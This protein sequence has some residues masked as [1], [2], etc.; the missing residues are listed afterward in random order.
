VGGIPYPAPLSTGQWAHD[1]LYELGDPQSPT[2]VGYWE[3]WQSRESPSGYGY[4][5]VGTEQTA[6]GSIVAPGNSATVQAFRSW[7]Q[8]L[9]ATKQTI[10]QNPANAQLEAALRSGNA[11]LAQLAAA[12]S[13][14]GASWATG[15]ESQITALGTST[16]FSY[17]GPMGLQK[18]S[19]GV[20]SVAG[21][22][23]P[24]AGGPG[25][26]DQIFHPLNPFGSN[27]LGLGT[28]G[29][30]VTGIPG[31]V[32]KSAFGPVF[33]WIEKG[34]ADVT[35]VGFGLLLVVIGLSVTFKGGA[36]MNVTQAAPASTSGGV[37]ETA[38]DA[39]EVAAA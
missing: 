9:L 22:K 1:I 25:L 19:P 10:T 30:T 35:F 6:P 36:S 33:S 2:N 31:D 32:A 4:N 8:G 13:V 20:A 17:G 16:P 24:S 3:A 5:P 37:K 26:L 14:P 15:G 18:G 11:T 38:S 27:F 34:A 29:H 39:A 7:A 12:Q 28:V 23:T 21:D